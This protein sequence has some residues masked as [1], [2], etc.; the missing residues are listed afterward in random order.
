MREVFLYISLTTVAVLF[1]LRMYVG[2]GMYYCSISVVL[3]IVYMKHNYV[4]MCVHFVCANHE[5]YIGVFVLCYLIMP[6]EYLLQD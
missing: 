1:V 5:Q 2:Y 6:G 3:F 4:C